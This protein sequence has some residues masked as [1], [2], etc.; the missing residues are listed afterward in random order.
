VPAGESHVDISAGVTF[1]ALDWFL[2]YANDS[3]DNTI[4]GQ[5]TVQVVLSP[6]LL[7]HFVVTGETELSPGEYYDLTVEAVNQYGTT[8]QTYVGTVHFA[9]DAPG[10]TYSLPANSP[11]ALSNNG[12]KVFTSAMRFSQT[13]TYEVNVSD[14]VTT[15][16]YGLLTGI[17]VAARPNIVYTAYDF[18]QEPWGEWYTNTKFRWDFYGRDYILSNTTGMNVQL[19]DTS[20]AGDGSQALIYAPYRFS[21]NATNVSN[22]DV[23]NPEFMPVNETVGPVAGAEVSMHVRMQYIDLPWWFSYFVKEF[24][25]G[26]PFLPPFYNNT[27]D[28]YLL[29]TVYDIELNREAAYEWMNM[30]MSETDPAAWW[31]AN[32][33]TYESWWDAWIYNEGNSQSRLDIWCGYEDYYYSQKLWMNMTVDTDGDILLRISHVN[34]GYEVLLVRWL[35]EV[36]LSTHQ[37]WFEDFDMDVTYG[38]GIANVSFDGAVQYGFHAVKANAS[39][40]NEGAWVFENVR[41]DYWP[42]WSQ[43]PAVHSSDYDPYAGP[44]WTPVAPPNTFQSWSAGDP[45]FGKTTVEYDTTPNRLQLN[46]FQT[47]IVK[48]PMGDVPGYLGQG[49]SSTAILNMSTGDTHDYDDL[50]YTGS[51]SLGFVITNST[52]P[53]DLTPLYNSVT[54]TL[55]I[56]GPFDFN[57]AGGRTGGVLYHG[58]PWIE[59][60]VTS[61]L[62]TESVVEAPLEVGAESAPAVTAEMLSLAVVICGVLIAVPALVG[63]RRED[64]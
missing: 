10:G 14:T 24:G 16:A 1:T 56:K 8:F 20:K 63:S 55:T 53:L 38:N 30:P 28:G 26:N 5:T 33:D 11:F 49:V 64:E 45:K 62:K 25:K 6:P 36:Q 50:R 61:T 34:W 15:T 48:L 22:V 42:S 58:A 31:T 23:H 27:Q 13:G 37:P 9:T 40:T 41:V 35:D 12:V 19:Y 47:L 51:A 4:T 52:N 29:G 7:D 44:S 3:V 46:E 21:M 43:A 17:N 57:N 54:K 18:F 32:R 39:A 2:V 60:N 59:F